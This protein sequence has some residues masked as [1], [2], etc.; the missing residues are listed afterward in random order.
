MHPFYSCKRL[1][2]RTKDLRKA[3]LIAHGVTV[4]Y[5]TKGK[6]LGA[7]QV[8]GTVWAKR[9]RNSHSISLDRGQNLSYSLRSRSKSYF[10]SKIEVNMW[11]LLLSHLRLHPLSRLTSAEKCGQ[12]QLVK[13]QPT[14]IN[15]RISIALQLHTGRCHEHAFL[16][17]PVALHLTP[18]SR[19]VGG[20]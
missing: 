12:W 6:G 15:F 7:E 14:C 20:S 2:L 19:W 16:A 17:T 8:I 11:V 3:S 10:L 1:G 18:V 9:G 13:E 4:H 5:R